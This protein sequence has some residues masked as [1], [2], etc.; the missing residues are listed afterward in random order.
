MRYI[1]TLFV[2]FFP[3]ITFSQT[4]NSTPNAKDAKDN[5]TLGD[6]K[7]ALDEYL[8]LIKN[9]TDNVTYNFRIGVCY[10]NTD[11]D[12]S[13]AMHY[14]EKA[15][16][17]PK[18]DS[19]AWYELGHAYLVNYKI[20]KAIDCF[21][22]YKQLANGKEDFEISAE[23]MIQMCEE[24][25]KQIAHPVNITIENL[26]PEVNSPYPDF[27]PYIPADESFLVFTSKKPGNTGNLQDYDGYNTSDIYISF[28]KYDKWTKAKSIGTTINSN[29]VEE[30]VGLTQDGNKLLLYNDNYNALS[31]VMVSDRKGKTFQKPE[32]LGNKLNPGKVVT[33]ATISP[34]KKTLVL[35]TD[36]NAENGGRDL[37]ISHKL[38]SGEWS[39]CENMGTPVNTVYNEDFPFFAVDGKTLYFSSQGH[40]SMGGYD[41]FKS[42]YNEKADTWSEPENLGYPVNTTDDD[43]TIS[44]SATGRH[45]F[46][47][48]H[49]KD[50]YG[51]LDIYKIIF[52]DVDPAYTMISGTL[53][54]SDSMSIFRSPTNTAND[55]L[56]VRNLDKPNKGSSGHKDTVPPERKNI[57][58]SISII[59]K[60]SQKIIGRYL[61]DKRTG[62]FL[63][64]LPP[65]TFDLDI[66]ADGYERYTET[67]KIPDRAMNSEIMKDIVLY[68]VIRMQEKKSE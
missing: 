61:P 55:S 31:Q 33:A 60:A 8:V 45:G 43:F 11:I 53:V 58:I 65:G 46:I 49:R 5:F 47:A 32:F 40:N 25:K 9:D 62:K 23:R 48:S 63:I 56:H 26:G 50:C 18:I 34:D 4:D 15:T 19:K 64:I 1:F 24:A 38:P 68:P 20:D 41:I 29:L 57:K 52:N 39:P 10:I 42:V 27:N 37:Y 6:F 28:Q 35:A 66:N 16:A 44:L 54:S 17:D 59:D 2:L 13:K 14:L 51:D 21:N 3:I 12:K 7:D 36:K 30:T 22:K 67:F